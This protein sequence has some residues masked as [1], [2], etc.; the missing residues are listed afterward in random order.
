MVGRGGGL[1]GGGIHAGGVQ[2]GSMQRPSMH[3]QPGSSHVAGQSMVPQPSLVGPQYWIPAIRQ[4]RFE[5]RPASVRQRWS[6][7]QIQ[8]GWGQLA[9]Q[10]RAPPQPSPIRPQYL[11]PV[12]EIQEPLLHSPPESRMQKPP[13][14]T[15]PRGQGSLVVSASIEAPS[16]STG[17]SAGRSGPARSARPAS[18]DEESSCPS[19]SARSRGASLPSGPASRTGKSLSTPVNPPASLSFSGASQLTSAPSF[20]T[21]VSVVKPAASTVR[22]EDREHPPA[23]ANQTRRSRPCM[24]LIPS[25]YHD[26]IHGAAIDTSRRLLPSPIVG[27]GGGGTMSERSLAAGAS[28]PESCTTCIL[29]GGIVVASRQSRESGSM[30]MAYIAPSGP[31]ACHTHPCPRGCAA[32]VA[33]PK[34]LA[35]GD[36]H[37]TVWEQAEAF[38]GQRKLLGKPA[39]PVG[40]AGLAIKQLAGIVPHRGPAI[41]L[42]RDKAMCLTPDAVF[43]GPEDDHTARAFVSAG[44]D[45]LRAPCA[46]L[47]DFSRAQ[48]VHVFGSIHA[49]PRGQRAV[50]APAPGSPRAEHEAA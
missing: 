27:G 50:F 38:L 25:P 30:S 1:T 5:Q 7:P 46:V 14:H 45:Y 26:P 44:R 36:A 6:R 20:D 39:L 3:C 49:G 11:A 15:Q 42:D 16:E 19:T 34:W 4:A 32:P 40:L 8:P 13:T 31:R 22:S 17:L 37:E 18:C 23:S 21:V 9:S 47:L 43:L 35:E 33:I 24:P 2:L 12:A 48:L 41:L 29:G 28:T 10:S